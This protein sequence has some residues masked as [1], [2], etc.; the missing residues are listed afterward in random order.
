MLKIKNKKI[1]YIVSALILGTFALIP[2]TSRAESQNN[3]SNYGNPRFRMMQ[4]NNDNSG[5]TEPS[6]DGRWQGRGGQG[7][8]DRGGLAGGTEPGDNGRGNG[9]GKHI[10]LRCEIFKIRVTNRI[11]MFDV[12]EKFHQDKFENIIDRISALITKL[13]GQGVDT[14]KLDADLLVLK[15]KV[16]T[17]NQQYQTLI[18]ILKNLQN[19]T[20][21]TTTDTPNDISSPLGSIKT[22]VASLRATV[23]DIRTYFINTIKPDLQALNIKLGMSGRDDGGRLGGKSN[24]QDDSGQTSPGDN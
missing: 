16:T 8:F 4:G 1:P 19:V 7:Q 23:L 20:C 13:K 24:P 9:E 5:T 6:G 3:G 17:L 11:R 12:S 22:L 14:T 10:L 21:N 15:G 18:G 2:I